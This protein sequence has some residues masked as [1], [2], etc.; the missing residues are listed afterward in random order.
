MIAHLLTKLRGA[1][2]LYLLFLGWSTICIL[3]GITLMWFTAV[4]V[5]AGV[6]G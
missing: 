5:C 2:W 1:Y 3:A 4:A 6:S